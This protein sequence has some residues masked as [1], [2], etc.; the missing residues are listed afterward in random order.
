MMK[1]RGFTLIELIIVVIII[2]ILA[3]IAAPMMS[4]M[5]ARA[6]VTEAVTGMSA[7]RESLREYY[8]E[9]SQYPSAIMGVSL[10]RPE[11]FPGLN[12]RPF[13]T[14]GGSSLDGLYFSEECY[15][16]SS[17]MHLIYCKPYA[18]GYGYG[19]IA[20]KATDAENASGP[21]G[22]AQYLQMDIDTGQITA[23]NFPGS[24]Y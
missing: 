6:I 17:L 11:C 19:N 20:P 10:D 16:F 8:V 3:S 14:Y 24:G 21:P 2:G 13:G 22:S 18:G 9:N 12:I 15:E 7:I 1:K 4:G 5:R 23:N